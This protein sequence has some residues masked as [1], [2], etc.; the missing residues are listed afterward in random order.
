MLSHTP[1]SPLVA[2]RA[3]L[4]TDQPTEEIT[5]GVQDRA[6]ETTIETDEEDADFDQLMFALKVKEK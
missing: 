4:L 5:F 6:V 1:Q 3:R 2:D